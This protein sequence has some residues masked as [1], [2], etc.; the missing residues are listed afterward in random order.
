MIEN[1]LFNGINLIWITN[2]NKTYKATSGLPRWQHP[3][4]QQVRE[5]GPTPE[6]L[7]SVAIFY[8]GIAEIGSASS[9]Q[10]K[11]GWG[12]Q[13]VPGEGAATSRDN[14]DCWDN[15]WVNWGTTRLQFAAVKGAANAAPHRSGFYIHNSQK[16][17]SH[18]CIE[19]ENAF[20]EDMAIYIKSV[21]QIHHLRLRVRYL[22]DNM[23]TNGGTGKALDGWTIENERSF[24]IFCDA[25]PENN[26]CNM[27]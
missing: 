13:N 24:Q 25:N 26:R 23:V 2:N 8:N 1:L 10:L 27:E 18:G 19:V 6:G 9:C 4:F 11:S 14:E 5:K 22:S 3:K 12:I 21:S 20:F 17:Y 15:Y 16:G 7:Y